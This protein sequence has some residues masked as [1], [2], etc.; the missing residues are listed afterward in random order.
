MDGEYKEGWD[1]TEYATL[2]REET[3]A[4]KVDKAVRE[5][6]VWLA[7]AAEPRETEEVKRTGPAS[8]APCLQGLRWG[9]TGRIQ[10]ART[11]QGSTQEDRERSDLS[12]LWGAYRPYGVPMRG[13]SR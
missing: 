5:R 13:G 4:W 6:R 7:A 12:H 11:V 8:P 10:E 9:E 3:I 2:L 1:W